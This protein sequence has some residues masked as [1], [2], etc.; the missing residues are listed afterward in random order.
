VS[1]VPPLRRNLC[2]CVD[3]KDCCT[4]CRYI[5]E[6]G[7]DEY[8]IE[9]VDRLYDKILRMT[10]EEIKESIAKYNEKFNA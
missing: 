3:H 8:R 6:L 7:P 2:S 1:V 9:L 5:G 10:P 4:C